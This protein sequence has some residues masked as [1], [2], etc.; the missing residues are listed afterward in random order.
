MPFCSEKERRG[1]AL[2]KACSRVE[3]AGRCL[4]RVREGAGRSVGRCKEEV[5]RLHETCSFS[6]QSFSAQTNR[7]R[8]ERLDERRQERERTA[9]GVR[10]KS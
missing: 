9:E 10:S 1:E 5:R 3:L 7:Q 4:F 6:L 2:Y 8:T